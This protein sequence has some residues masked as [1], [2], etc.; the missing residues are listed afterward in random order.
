[1]FGF[2][3]KEQSTSKTTDSLVQ[4][5]I[6]YLTG[7]GVNE[8]D[9]KAFELFK[10]AAEQNHPEGLAR[11]GEMYQYGYGCDCNYEK[12]F[13][14]YKKSAELGSGRGE[15]R[16]GWLYVH[17]EFYLPNVKTDMRQA[18]YYYKRAYEHGYRDQLGILEDFAAT[19]VVPF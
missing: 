1:M 13:Y 10:S 16:L 15:F 12:A 11:L 5:G 19:G 2:L 17:A 4:A 18:A 14:Y 6:A 8:D 7:Q 9:Q 3:K